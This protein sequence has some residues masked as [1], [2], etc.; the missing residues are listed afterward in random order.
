M[1]KT[2]TA[3]A[4]HTPDGVINYPQIRIGEDGHILSVE[5]GEA[6]ADETVLTSSFLDVHIHG[7]VGHDV[8][9]TSASG[10]SEIER[11]LATRGVGH[12]LPT[13]VT[14][15]IDETMRAM[16]RIAEH[17]ESADERGGEGRATPVGVHLEGPFLS[18]SKR[19][20]HNAPDL[21]K[22]DVALF[23]RFQQAARGHIR[24]LTVAPEVPGALELIAHATSR[25]VRVSMGHT[26]ATAA[27][28][29]AAI[30]AGASSATHTFNAMRAMDH[31]EPGVVGVVLTSEE[32]FAELICDGIHVAPEMVRL[33]AKCKSVDKFILVTDG[34]SAAGMPDGTYRLGNFDVQVKDGHATAR[35]VLAGS[36]VTL[37]RAVANFAKFTG[38][39]V[40]AVTRGASHNP[41][42]MLGL[43]ERF[44]LKV[45]MPAN[46]NRFAADGSLVE[47][48]LCGKPVASGVTA[49]AA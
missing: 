44:L 9:E 46:F 38:R 19:G 47:T 39:S 12:Y 22:P 26:N 48:I 28:T 4:L 42:K 35:G 7:A 15:P 8:M 21:L 24:L 32:T 41:A 30:A 18:H 34:M 37:D 14:A 45:G 1:A 10:F 36:V 29:H 6:H 11:F 16:E 25:G 5:A 49:G 40:A 31:R 3:R 27:E 20:V 23:D 33:F 17:I 13:T 43:E 2:I